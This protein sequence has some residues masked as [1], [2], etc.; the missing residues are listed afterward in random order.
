MTKDRAAKS[1]R[2]VPP[3]PSCASSSNAV[4]VKIPS[5]MNKYKH[6]EHHI[7]ADPS[8]NDRPKGVQRHRETARR[9]HPS[10]SLNQFLVMF[11]HISGNLL[12]LLPLSLLLPP[13]PPDER[14][15]KAVL[16]LSHPV[17]LSTHK[18]HLAVPSQQEKR[19]TRSRRRYKKVA[20][21]ERREGCPRRIWHATGPG[22][23]D[24]REQD[25]RTAFPIFLV[26]SFFQ[27][28]SRS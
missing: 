1:A 13:S 3:V 2:G 10:C 16:T 12:L 15:R 7:K 9:R 19:D 26:V 24:E 5:A 18:V 6:W 8:I 28:C 25:D 21:V 20:K 11:F 17:N 22:D 4:P 23:P 27:G 14:E